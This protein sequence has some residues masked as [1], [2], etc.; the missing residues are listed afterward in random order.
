MKACL[1]GRGLVYA[2]T[3]RKKNVSGEGGKANA[4]YSETILTGKANEQCVTVRKLT[5]HSVKTSES[6]K[7]N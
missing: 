1:L 2:E 7:L 6:T 3:R 4:Q 5:N